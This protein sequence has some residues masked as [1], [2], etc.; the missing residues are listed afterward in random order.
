[1]KEVGLSYFKDA[2]NYPDL[3]LFIIYNAYAFNVIF[4]DNEEE[5]NGQMTTYF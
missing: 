4:Y 1:M 5:Y 2:W 3:L